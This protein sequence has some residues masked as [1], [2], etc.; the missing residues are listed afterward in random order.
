MAARTLDHIGMVV[1]DIHQTASRINSI[2]GFAIAQSEDYGHGLLSIA[3]IPM[4]EGLNGPKLELLQPNR[5]G[6]SAWEF[7]QSQGEGVEHVAFLVDDVDQELDFLRGQI[8]LLDNQ[9]KS[10]AGN[11]HIAFLGRDAIPGLFTELVAPV[12]I[13]GGKR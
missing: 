12:P 10:G 1:R 5:S 9:S 8:P 4:G 6:S 11:M 3:F 13:G 2:L 7:L